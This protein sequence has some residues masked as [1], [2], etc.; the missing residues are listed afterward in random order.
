MKKIFVDCS[1][2]YYHKELNTG[3]QRVVR[4]VIENLEE[5]SKEKNFK[6]I[7]VDISNGQFNRVNISDLYIKEN[8]TPPP[9]VEGK[10]TPQPLPQ[11]SFKKRTFEYLKNIYIHIKNLIVAI[12]PFK[13]VENF[14]L[15]GKDRFGLD[16]IIF[17]LTVWPIKRVINYPKAQR[18]KKALLAYQKEMEVRK[19]DILLLLDSTWYLNI[20]SRVE[21]CRKKEAHIV[22]VIYDIIPISHPMFCDDFLAQVFKDWF[23]TAI[24]YVDG[25]ITISDTVKIGLKEFLLKEIGDEVKKKKFDYFHLGSDFKYK[26]L[27]NS[28]VREDLKEFFKKRSTYLIVSTIEPR[29]NHK[30]LLDVFD[31]LWEKGVDV[32]LCI[33][34]RRGWKVDELIN[35]ITSHKEY[36]ERLFYGENINDRELLFAYDNAKMLLFPSIVEGFGLPIVESLLHKLPVLASD[37]P[38]HREVGGDKIGY[39]NIDDVSDLEKQIIEIE[40]KGI[41]EKLKVDENYKWLSWRDSTNMLLEKIERVTK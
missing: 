36:N 3:I 21:E 2:L 41:P 22:A 37:T 25:F 7:P 19:G 39:F 10:R 8:P 38:I 23:Y 20:W 33:I 30:Y 4:R 26:N 5:I 18:E 29:K 1:Y 28:E 16:Y 31:K 17:S 34:G 6:V 27:D 40:E 24:K 32:N 9:V 14:F 11:K 12:F 35:R 15:P 13:S